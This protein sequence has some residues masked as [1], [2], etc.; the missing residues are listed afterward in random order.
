MLPVG[1]SL[2]PIPFQKPQKPPEPQ[3]LEPMQGINLPTRLSLQLM[4]PNLESRWWRTSLP[5][6][7]SSQ[8]REQILCRA[9]ASPS[10]PGRRWAPEKRPQRSPQHLQMKV[11]PWWQPLERKALAN[12]DTWRNAPEAGLGLPGWKGSEATNP[13]P[14]P[15][16]GV[17]C[18]GC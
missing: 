7:L 13:Q 5:I 2:C 1:G 17:A 15:P 8:C 10:A 11:G 12:L 6:R 4:E 9:T 18:L 14:H 16:Q 3:L